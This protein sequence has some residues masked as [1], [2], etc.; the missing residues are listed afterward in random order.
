MASIGDVR[1]L[2]GE[3]GVKCPGVRETRENCVGTVNRMKGMMERVPVRG[4]GLRDV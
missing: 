4:W 2:G 3:G 1:G